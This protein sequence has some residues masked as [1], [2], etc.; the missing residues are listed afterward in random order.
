MS[1]DVDDRM[2]RGASDDAHRITWF[3]PGDR[4][5]S[6]TVCVRGHDQELESDSGFVEEG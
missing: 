1:D 2:E 5:V 3:D 4:P 6:G